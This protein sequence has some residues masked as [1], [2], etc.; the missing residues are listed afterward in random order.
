M[1]KKPKGIPGEE[2]L[3]SNRSAGH[4][5]HLIRRIEAG[6]VLHGAEVKSIRQGRIN[7]KESYASVRG[8][9]VF[10]Y[11]AH[12]SP[13]SHARNDEL[14]PVRPRK[15]LLHAQEIR[16]LVK[17]T[18]TTGMTLVPTRVYLKKGRVKVEIAVAKGKRAYDKRE[19]T[20]TRDVER[21]MQRARSVDRD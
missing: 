4:D 2:L 7:L 20:R 6:I 9:E 1:A 18:R 8:G 16:K 11:Q 14:D 12:V 15:L 3:A 5:Y 19:A 17:D 10:L 13:Y 21:E